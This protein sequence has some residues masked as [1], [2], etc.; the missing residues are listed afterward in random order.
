MWKKKH[1]VYQ[2]LHAG[3]YKSDRQI[4]VLNRPASEAVK[5]QVSGKVLKK[6][7]GD[8]QFAMFNE[9]TSR[10][11]RKVQTE[12]FP[13]FAFLILLFLG[14][15]GFMTLRRVPLREDVK[16]GILLQIFRLWI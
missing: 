12:L 8:L 11:E 4:L 16:W 5:H 7:F 9:K 15:E 3:V 1:A 14:V 6:L 13:M 10:S 2:N